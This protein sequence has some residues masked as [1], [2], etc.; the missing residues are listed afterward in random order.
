MKYAAFVDFNPEPSKVAENRPAHR[1]YLAAMKKAGKLVVAGPYI[2]MSGGI[3]VY[4][5]ATP[6]ETDQ[7]L[8]EDPFFTSGIFVKWVIRPWNPVMGNPEMLQP[9]PPAS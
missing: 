2:D 6:E 9:E 4:E 8:R 1:E 7:I 3:L 5:T